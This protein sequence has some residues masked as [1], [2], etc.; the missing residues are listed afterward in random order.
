[1]PVS[2]VNVMMIALI[3]QTGSVYSRA[4]KRLALVFLHLHHYTATIATS[5][6]SFVDSVFS[7]L[8]LI[9]LFI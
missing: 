4:P 5:A 7:H 6:I 3:I 2:N 9:M 8:A 1:M